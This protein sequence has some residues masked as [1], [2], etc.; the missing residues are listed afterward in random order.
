MEI[1]QHRVLDIQERKDINLA[2]EK[3]NEKYRTRVKFMIYLPS[4]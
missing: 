1:V 4:R 2:R 3:A